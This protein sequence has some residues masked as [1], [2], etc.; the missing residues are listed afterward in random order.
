MSWIQRCVQQLEDHLLVC[1]VGGLRRAGGRQRGIS[2]LS[3]GNEPQTLQ[4]HCLMSVPNA[5]AKPRTA[6]GIPAR[7][8]QV[9]VFHT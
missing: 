1:C 3:I 2:P 6:Y 8:G 4:V 5:Y 9:R 7:W